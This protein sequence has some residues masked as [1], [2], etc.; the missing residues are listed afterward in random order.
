MELAEAEV[1]TPGTRIFVR[2]GGA[3]PPLLLLHGFPQTHLMWRDVA[4]DL[5]RDFTVVCADLRG[6]GRSGCPPSDDRHAPYA[7][8]ALAEDMIAVMDALGHPAFAVAGH[9]RGGRVAYRAALDHPARVRRV[10]VLDI[11]PVDTVWDRADD[12]LALGVLAVVAARAARAAA[13][14]PARRA[15]P[16][17][18]STARSAGTGARRPRRSRPRSAPP[19]SRRCRIPST[20]TRSARSTAPRPGSTASTTAPTARRAGGSRA[21]CSRCGAASGPVGTWYADAGGPLAL[22]RELADDVQRRGRRRRPLLPGGASARHRR[23]AATVLRPVTAPIRV[24]EDE[25]IPTRDGSWL[26]A[27]RFLPAGPARTRP[28]SSSCPTARTRAR[29]SRPAR[30]ATSRRTAT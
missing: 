6:Y 16:P 26:A 13:R 17:R 5:A 20:S 30:T 10:A 27:N 9:D 23:G 25:R 12:R 11:L 29:P 7:K 22:W 2:H 28:C 3:G 4:A 21:R 18:W 8:R 14:A 19:T 24:V 15:R 1:D